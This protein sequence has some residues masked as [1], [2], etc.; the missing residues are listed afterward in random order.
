LPCWA[1]RYHLA[2]R[3]AGG[4]LGRSMVALS[5]APAANACRHETV[6]EIPRVGTAER[7]F[8][9]RGG[10][11]VSGK[12]ML[13]G[14]SP[15]ICTLCHLMQHVLLSDCNVPCSDSTKQGYHRGSS[16]SG[17]SIGLDASLTATRAIVPLAASLLP[18]HCLQELPRSAFPGSGFGRLPRSNSF[19]S[20]AP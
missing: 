10:L 13:R 6:P 19:P 11:V 1:T 18:S 12:W 8:F 20:R 2:G 16:K 5:P 7:G 9:S 15:C 17:D 4:V 14:Q 3:V